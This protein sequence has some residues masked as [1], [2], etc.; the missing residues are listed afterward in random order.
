MSQSTSAEMAGTGDQL[1][2][3]LDTP[4]KSIHDVGWDDGRAYVVGFDPER[5][6]RLEVFPDHGVVCLTSRDTQIT[7]FRKGPPSLFSDQVRFEAGTEDEHLQFTL[8]Q[9][10]R[11]Q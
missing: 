6:S 4:P 8:T 10:G 3:V 7:L 2:E 1:A 11:V 9:R 5:A